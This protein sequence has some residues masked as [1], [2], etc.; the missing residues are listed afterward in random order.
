MG[1][2]KTRLG[3]RIAVDLDLPFVDLDDRVEAAAGMPI[4]RLFGRFGETYFRELEHQCLIGTTRLPGAVIGTGG[5]TFTF[6][7]NRHLIRE[8]GTSLF[9]DVDFDTIAG[10][11]GPAGRAKRPLFDDPLRAREL[12][13]QRLPSYRSADFAV[14]V[15]P[16]DAKEAVAAR[17][18]RLI[19]E[20]PCDI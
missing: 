19:R 14:K 1:A 13:E 15:H 17:M 7:R 5:G 2:G 9:I 11:L 3:E 8:S 20:T 4:R 18:L 12:Y 10:R 16:G 6:E